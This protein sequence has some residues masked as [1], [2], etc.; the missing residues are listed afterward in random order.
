M[1]I[2][3]EGTLEPTHDT[4]KYVEIWR[5]QPDGKWLIAVDISNSDLPL[6]E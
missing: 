4:G 1:T 5:K 6:P 3:V 2:L